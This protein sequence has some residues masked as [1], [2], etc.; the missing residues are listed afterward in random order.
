VPDRDIE[1]P[2]RIESARLSPRLDPTLIDPT[3]PRF[4]ATAERNSLQTREDRLLRQPAPG[5]RLSVPFTY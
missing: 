2:R 1:G 4:G 5:A 3:E